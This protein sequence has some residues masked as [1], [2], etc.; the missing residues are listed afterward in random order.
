MSHG[1]HSPLAGCYLRLVAVRHRYW[2]LGCCNIGRPRDTASNEQPVRAAALIG[3]R[4]MKSDEYR[5]HAR[6]CL[7]RNG[8]CRPRCSTRAHQH[9][10]HD[11]AICPGR[12]VGTGC[13]RRGEGTTMFRAWMRREHWLI[14]LT[15]IVVTEHGGGDDR[16]FYVSAP[17]SGCGFNGVRSRNAIADRNRLLRAWRWMRATR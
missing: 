9:R 7:E 4:K 13:A 12:S 8:C 14:W 2:T 3:R 1:E 17:D 11:G 10:P 16:L 6:E 15:A 5:A